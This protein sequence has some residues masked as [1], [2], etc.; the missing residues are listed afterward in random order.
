MIRSLLSAAVALS[1]VACDDSTSPRDEVIRPGDINVVSAPST[2]TAYVPF[3]V[4]ISTRGSGCLLGPAATRLEYSD[5]TVLIEVLDRWAARG[6]CADEEII[7]DH[8]IFI[9][10]HEAGITRIRVEGLEAEEIDIEVV[11]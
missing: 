9:E 1:M 10:L 11:L 3:V 5:D 4:E 8:S 7:V 2:V 6:E